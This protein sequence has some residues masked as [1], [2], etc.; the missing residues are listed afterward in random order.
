[1]LVE[2]NKRDAEFD[3]KT[4]SKENAA[5]LRWHSLDSS[6]ET[7]SKLRL[8][9][10]NQ[11]NYSEIAQV[12]LILCQHYCLY[13]VY[14]L[15]G[16]IISSVHKKKLPTFSNSSSSETAIWCKTEWC[17]TYP[18]MHLFTFSYWRAALN[19]HWQL[20]SSRH[21]GSVRSGGRELREKEGFADITAALGNCVQ[22]GIYVVGIWFKGTSKQSGG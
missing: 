18:E 2:K 17:A 21:P 15:K 4:Y 3:S 5:R 6:N 1:M 7:S 19:S 11:K 8:S 16:A 13:N 22:C 14:G 12:H 9:T 10:A 20:S